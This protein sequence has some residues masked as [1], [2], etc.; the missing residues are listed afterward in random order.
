M[1][2]EYRFPVLEADGLKALPCEY[3]HLGQNAARLQILAG[4]L[5]QLCHCFPKDGAIG[6]GDIQGFGK[7]ELRRN[8]GSVRQGPCG[9]HYQEPG[10][11]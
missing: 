10:T 6:E 4:R 5:I 11:S 9:R 2:G 8:I 7:S 1:Y 3:A